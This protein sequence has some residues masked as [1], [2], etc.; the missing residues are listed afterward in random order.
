MKAT[1]KAKDLITARSTEDLVRDFELTEELND[2]N[3]P[4]VRGWIMDELERRN[5]EAFWAW[6]E[7]EN[8]S[9][10]EFYL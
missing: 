7:S 6:I 2:K 3:I 8:E 9:P 10:R 4:T 5:S 1:E